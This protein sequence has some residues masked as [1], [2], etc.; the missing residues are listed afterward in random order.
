MVSS[1]A[2]AAIESLFCPQPDATDRPKKRVASPEASARGITRR[3][4]EEARSLFWLV[5]QQGQTAS[6]IREQICIPPHAARE[7]FAFVEDHPDEAPWMLAA[8]Q[9]RNFVLR[10]FDRI[11]S[12]AKYAERIA[13]AE[14]E[15]ARRAAAEIPVLPL[16]HELVRPMGSG[17]AFLLES[18]Q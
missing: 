2:L 8:V 17:K 18:N 12:A 13:A 3:V 7:M 9:F 1:A 5:G 11:T 4:R 16:L 15:A 14:A 10:E 6:S